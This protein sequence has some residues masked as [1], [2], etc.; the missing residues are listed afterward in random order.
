MNKL[1]I[2]WVHEWCQKYPVEYDDLYYMPYIDAARQGD[3]QAI[4]ALTRWKNT[5]STGRPMP[6]SRKKKAALNFFLS[7]LDLY[8]QPDGS[9]LL[10][11][12]FQYRAPVWSIF[13][14]HILYG[15]PILDRYTH[16]VYQQFS[17]GKRISLE[18][19]TISYPG[20]WQL[21]DEYRLW[22]DAEQHHLSQVDA[23]I[24]ARVLDRALSMY[25]INL[26]KTL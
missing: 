10:R 20:H 3:A 23:T 5:S 11:Q 16:M 24:S 8:L 13:W 19:A 17:R 12:D 22:F 18:D 4:E 14:H 21:F 7:R 25:G 9:A 15:T 26:A 1:T 6:L 2:G